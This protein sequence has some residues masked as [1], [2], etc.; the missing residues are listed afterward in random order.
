MPKTV[1]I[2][3]ETFIRWKGVTEEVETVRAFSSVC[4]IEEA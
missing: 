4:I 2:R 1:A 3:H